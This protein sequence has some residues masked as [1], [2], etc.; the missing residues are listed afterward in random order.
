MVQRIG[1]GNGTG[2]SFGLGGWGWRLAIFVLRSPKPFRLITSMVI[3]CWPE[4]RRQNVRST[5][6]SIAVSMLLMLA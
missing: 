1:A 3:T 4:T 5:T 2:K 6:V